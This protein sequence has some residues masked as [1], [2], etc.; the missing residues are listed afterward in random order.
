MKLHIHMSHI[1]LY[2]YAPKPYIYAQRRGSGARQNQAREQSGNRTGSR[3]ILTQDPAKTNKNTLF[4][5]SADQNEPTQFGMIWNTLK[6]I[7]VTF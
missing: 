4:P 6:Y 3:S 5:A 2:I 1:Y 7:W